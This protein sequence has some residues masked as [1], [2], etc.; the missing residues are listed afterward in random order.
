MTTLRHSLGSAISSFWK[1]TSHNRLNRTQVLM[2]HSIGGNADGDRRG[3]YSVSPDSFRSQIEVLDD[4]A[5]NGTSIVVPFG[6]ELPGQVSVTFDDGYIDNL[7]IVAPTMIEK[8]F[9]FHVFLCPAFIDSDRTGFLTRRDVLELA[10]MPGV[11]LGVHGY[12]HRPLTTLDSNVLRTDLMSSRQWLEDLIQRPVTSM[13]YPHG[14]VDTRVI[15]FVNEA[16]FTRAAC[17]KFGPVVAGSD[18]LKIPRVDIWSTDT[19]SS[20]TS[21][22]EGHWDWMRWRT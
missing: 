17:S 13:S 5:T 16:G 1:L 21:K 6:D 2:Y 19:N 18:L 22:I 14:A 20:F 10:A 7:S 3:L 4:L 8:A 11:T 12:S 15:A 9:P